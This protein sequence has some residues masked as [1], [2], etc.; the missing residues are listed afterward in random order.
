LEQV[1]ADLVDKVEC[2]YYG[3][4]RGFVVDN[5]DPLH[6]GRLKLTVPS[7]LGPDVVTG[8]ALP[9]VPYGGMA[10]QGFLFIPEN[11]AG[12]WVEFE[13]GNLDFPIWSGTFWSKPEGASELPRPNDKDGKEA[14]AEQ[15]PP[16][17]KIIKTVKGHTIQ[18]EDADVEDGDGEESSSLRIIISDGEAE[19]R[20]VFRAAG[21][22]VTN[23]AN[24][25]TMTAEGIAIKD[26]HGNT[27]TMDAA[28]GGVPETPGIKV[29]GERMVCLD[30]LITWL[31]KH[32][33]LGNM[34][35]PCPL[36]PVDSAE[37]S[38]AQ[39]TPDGEIVSKR[40]K[41]G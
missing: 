36:N 13:E 12:V 18:L 41:L 21:V 37:L 31:L 5:A 26:A 23:K 40:V 25:I 35:A 7:V 24:S 19:N 10:N 32:T 9:C 15:H 3:K 22:F 14:E 1:V 20:I 8:W 17:R 28:S 30:G 11:K 6:L 33:H 38:K 16:T 4:Y 29:N 39:A 27:I 2:R 34:G